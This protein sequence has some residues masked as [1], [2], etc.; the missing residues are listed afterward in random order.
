MPTD[1][2]CDVMSHSLR[3]VT[4]ILWPV[5][6]KTP[7]LRVVVQ[8]GLEQQYVVSPRTK[9][10]QSQLLPSVLFRSS[11]N[12]TSNCCILKK[13]GL[14]DKQFKEGAM[15]KGSFNDTK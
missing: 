4:F 8:L 6:K 3:C 2:R 14:R 5:K 9:F 11:V 12:I 7:S 10:F 13:G 1:C 15:V